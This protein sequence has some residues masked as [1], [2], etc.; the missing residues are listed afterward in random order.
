MQE[1]RNVSPAPASGL[2]PFESLLLEHAATGKA[3]HIAGAHDALSARVAENAGFNGVWISSLAVSAVA[4][5]CDRNEVSWG[6]MVDVVERVSESCT[7]PII[8]DG[9]E[10]FGD[11]NIARLY[12]RRAGR[13][14][15]SCISIEDKTFPKKNSFV[16]DVS[17][18]SIREFAGKI[19][20]CREAIGDGRTSIVARTDSLVAGEDISQTFERA[21]AYHE[22]G[23][24]A[25]IIHSKAKTPKELE[26]FMAKWDRRC[27]IIA[28][29]TSYAP[30][31]SRL[32]DDL[33]VACVVWANQMLRASI[34]AMEE[35]AEAL[36]RRKSDHSLNDRM[37]SVRTAM[38]YANCGLGCE[39]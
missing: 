4:G 2:N 17:L 34:R 38:S 27:P 21:C 22:A 14:G 3:A 12:A 23:A 15:A 7:L 18:C 1:I 30:E 5:K 9:D 10:G 28:I 36:V 13:R 20:G 26:S 39:S 19:R 32:F 16:D 35:T 6:E 25:L 37:V 11:V 8:L 24:E 31:S 29:P 33:G